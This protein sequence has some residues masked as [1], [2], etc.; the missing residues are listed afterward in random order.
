MTSATHRPEWWD[1]ARSTLAD[2][3]LEASPQRRARHQPRVGRAGRPRRRRTRD[4][5]DG[6]SAEAPSVAAAERR[7]APRP[8]QH[9]REKQGRGRGANRQPVCRGA[10]KNSQCCPR[11]ST[12]SSQG[13]SRDPLVGPRQRAP[14]RALPVPRKPRGVAPRRA[15]HATP[16]DAAARETPEAPS[17]AAPL[18]RCCAEEATATA[19]RPA[20]L[21]LQRPL[22]AALRRRQSRQQQQPAPAPYTEVSP[23]ALS[24]AVRL[25]LRGSRKPLL[26]ACA[27]LARDMAGHARLGWRADVLKDSLASNPCPGLRTHER[28]AQFAATGDARPGHELAGAAVSDE[29]FSAEEKERVGILTASRRGIV[30]WG[31]SHRAASAAR[32]ARAA[33]AEAT[34][35]LR[36][37]EERHA[38]GAPRRICRSIARRAAPRPHTARC[39]AAAWRG[40]A[41]LPRAC[42]RAAVFFMRGGAQGIARTSRG[43]WTACDSTSRWRRCGRQGFDFRRDSQRRSGSPQAP[44]CPVSPRAVPIGVEGFR[45]AGQPGGGLAQA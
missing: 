18:V 30:C 33:R 1:G 15:R 12:D 42:R 10:G 23:R 37:L 17:T 39:A 20:A 11:A 36:G 26:F 38:R 29:A 41:T 44:P 13:P 28:P 9:G 2:L 16:L 5:A 14:W 4:G 24:P 6:R 34:G 35:K 43:R 19:G 25:R 40:G 8:R 7:S 45:R 31:Q 27:T 3:G 22:Q 21:N 32:T